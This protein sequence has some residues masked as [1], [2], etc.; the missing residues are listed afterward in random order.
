M[1]LQ[2]SAVRISGHPAACTFNGHPAACSFDCHP[3]PSVSECEGSH[4]GLATCKRSIVRS[5]A[6]LGMTNQRARAK[7]HC[8]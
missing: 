3:E 7:A 2:L 5:L 4:L 1:L 8:Y 6:P